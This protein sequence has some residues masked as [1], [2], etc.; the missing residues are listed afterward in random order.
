MN[1]LQT[2]IG[3]SEEEAQSQSQ[4]VASRSAGSGDGNRR[5]DHRIDRSDAAFTFSG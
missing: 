2:A 3:E 5:S 1:A 4:A